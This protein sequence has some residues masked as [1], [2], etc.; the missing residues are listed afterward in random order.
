MSNLTKNAI[1]DTFVEILTDRPLS[2][3]TVKDIVEKLGINRNTF[4]YHFKDIPDLIEELVIEETNR[5]ITKYPTVDSVEMAFNA[6]IDFAEKN[7]R[8]INHIYNSIK[9]S[10]RKNKT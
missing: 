4:Y 2:Q 6:A 3:I 5:I 10:L 8:A 7:R 1:K 9:N